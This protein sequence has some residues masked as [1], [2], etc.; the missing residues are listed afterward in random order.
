MGFVFDGVTSV[1][2]IICMTSLILAMIAF[3]SLYILPEDHTIIS[4]DTGNYIVLTDEEH[5]K[6][7][8]GDS[9]NQ[10]EALSSYIFK[11]SLLKLDT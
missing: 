11:S 4:C 8:S 9:L 5:E 10:E 2:L 1:P 7:L 6:I 3:F